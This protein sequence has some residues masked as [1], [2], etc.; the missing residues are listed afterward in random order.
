MTKVAVVAGATGIVGSLIIEQ[1]I[2]NT[3]ESEW[4][5][6][7]AISRRK[8]ELDKEDARF[9]HLP[10]D[11]TS[12][13]EE[14]AKKLKEGGAAEATHVFYSAYV[15]EKKWDAKTLY[16]SNVPMF[17]TF[18]KAI[19]SVAKNLQRIELQTGGKY[20]GIHLGW[21]HVIDD[22]SPRYKP[23]KDKP[24]FYMGQEDFL[25]SFQQGK[26]WRYT[27][28]RP[29]VISGV[30]R[31]NG[32]SM[33]VSLAIYFLIQKHLG[34]KALFPGNEVQYKS[35]CDCSNAD[36]IAKFAIWTST[37]PAAEN[38][39]FIIMDSDTEHETI[40]EQWKAMANYFGVEVEEPK[41]P[42]THDKPKGSGHY[43]L[44]YSLAEYMKDK[45]AC[46]ERNREEVW[47]R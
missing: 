41:F 21:D 28:Y 14:I 40:E 43:L 19:D 26:K 18:I 27:I 23:E 24:D 9:V 7:I 10:I 17:K 35:I 25:T 20:Y 2:K 5:K 22:N 45:K 46:L 37:L 36:I 42:K 34:K 32:M 1:L 44:E 33:A 12:S 11:L 6:I 4:S 8:P 16:E 47:R 13:E 38:N 30:T 31:G 3:N 15:H 39:D 29:L